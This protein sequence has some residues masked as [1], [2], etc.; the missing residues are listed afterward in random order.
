MSLKWSIL[1]L[2]VKLEKIFIKH[3]RAFRIFL[4]HCLVRKIILVV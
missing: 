1:I 2:K 3:F 4:V